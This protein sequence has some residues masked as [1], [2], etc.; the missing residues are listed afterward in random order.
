LLDLVLV[1]EAGDLLCGEI[2]YGGS[3]FDG[4]LLIDGV[5]SEFDVDLLALAYGE[6]DSGAALGGEAGELD[7]DGVG[8]DRDGGGGEAAIGAGGEAALVA[9]LVVV[10]EDLG[11]GQARTG[12]VGDGARESSA[13]YLS[14]CA[15]GEEEKGAEEK[16]FDG[17]R[18]GRVGA[19]LHGGLRKMGVGARFLCA[20]RKG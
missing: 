17:G 13:Y 19:V 10:D 6:G 16:K 1:D 3:V 18:V 15:E 14:V 12:G 2:D 20:S 5:D 4:N 8:T 9:S 7:C 11:V